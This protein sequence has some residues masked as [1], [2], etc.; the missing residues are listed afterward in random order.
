MAEGGG[1]LIVIS[2]SAIFVFP[3]KSLRFNHF[4]DQAS[5]LLLALK[6]RFW[7]LVGTISG[8]VV[9]NDQPLAVTTCFLDVAVEEDG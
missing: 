1:L 3:R 8:T 9:T 6:T 2:L 4:L 5:W 7:E